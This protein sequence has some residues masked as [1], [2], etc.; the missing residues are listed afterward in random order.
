MPPRVLRQWRLKSVTRNSVSPRWPQ[1]R[2][3]LPPGLKSR[4]GRGQRWGLCPPP[5]QS[6][7]PTR[8]RRPTCWR[9]R[10][11][12]HSRRCPPPPPPPVPS[13][14]HRPRPPREAG[15]L[16]RHLRCVRLAPCGACV[17]S[18]ASSSSPRRRAELRSDGEGRQCWRWV[19]ECPLPLRARLAA[20]RR[21]QPLCGACDGPPASG[22]DR[23]AE[24]RES[25]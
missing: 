19:R 4:R 10:R 13:R 24:G 23:P 1:P 18:A 7:P 14:P 3:R 17:W 21:I 6:R 25:P 5:P 8:R 15:F 22:R 2:L 9:G 20:P 12:R 16:R 11:D